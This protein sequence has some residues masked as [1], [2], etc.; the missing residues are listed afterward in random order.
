SFGSSIAGNV[1]S[2]NNL[3]V[4]V[5]R[6]VD[7]SGVQGAVV[8]GGPGLDQNR[9][10]ANLGASQQGI[11]ILSQG[12][13]TVQIDNNQIN[14]NTTGIVIQGGAAAGAITISGNEIAANSASSVAGVSISSITTS[15]VTVGGVNT[16]DA[17]NINLAAG[18]GVVASSV[19]GDVSVVGNAFGTQ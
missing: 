8:I 7:L 18:T 12:P 11:K 1:T 16:G 19:T 3:D 15:G 17:N 2:K 5:D 13:G 4:G 6:G 9:L 14:F 10:N